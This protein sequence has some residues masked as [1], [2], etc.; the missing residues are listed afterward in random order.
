MSTFREHCSSLQVHSQCQVASCPDEMNR[1]VHEMLAF[2]T[3]ITHKS[4]NLCDEIYFYYE[5]R[6]FQIF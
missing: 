2:G 6:T 1:N 3:E 5:S 4:F